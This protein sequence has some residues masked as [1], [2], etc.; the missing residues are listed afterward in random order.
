VTQWLALAVGALGGL[1]LVM[2]WIGWTEAPRPRQ[3][4][5]PWDSFMLVR[6]AAAVLSAAVV[7]LWTRW[8]VGTVAAFVAGY[9]AAGLAKG[10]RRSTRR[11][12]A[13]IEAVASWTEMLRDTL[14][15]GQGLAETIRSTAD[16]APPEIRP[17]VRSLA[18]RIERQRLSLALRE[19]AYEVDDPTADLVATVLIMAGTRTARDV[20]ELLSALAATAR[21]RASMRL[22]VDAQRAATRS[23][24]RSIIMTSLLFMVGITIFARRFVEPYGTAT[25]QLM[26]LL[27]V[28]IFGMGLWWLAQ[29]GRFERPERFLAREV[30]E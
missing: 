27:V 29:L 7:A 14:A 26:L 8:P 25:G 6:L 22:R 28:L 23:E 13:R 9:Y 11:E 15:A 3:E 4:L 10:G 21:E 12:L 18:V 20:G 24:V 19:W 17:Q 30:A 16:I 1:G 5:T 2:A